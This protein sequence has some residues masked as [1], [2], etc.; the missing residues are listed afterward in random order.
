MRLLAKGLPLLLQLLLWSAISNYAF[1]QDCQ[2][3]INAS[4]QLCTDGQVT[5]STNQAETYLW[6][7]GATTRSITVSAPGNYT[8]TTT[9]A[10]GCQGTSAAYSVSGKPD[11]KV[12]D[13]MTF[14]T[15]CSYSGNES[16][17]ELTLDNASTTK[18]TN[19]RYEIAWGDGSTTQFGKEFETATHT[20]R[21]AGSFKLA[22]TAY[23]AEGCSS[24]HE[25]R[26]FIG[27][28]PSLGL[29]SRGNTNDCSPATFVFD[30][31]NTEG[32]SPQTVYT[33]QFDDGSA[34]MTFTH[35]NLPKTIEHTFT[36][37]S[38]GRPGSAFTLTATAVN[39]CG[40]TPAT[41]GGIKISKGPQA[42]FGV[43]KEV[44]CVNVPIKLTDKTITGFNANAFNDNAAATYAVNWEI[45][46]AEGW[47]YTSGNAKANN[48]MVVFTQPGTYTIRM[49]A[50]P[51]GVNTKC[52]SSVQERVITINEP[53]KADFILQGS[54]NC[55]PAQFKA[56]NSSTGDAL[57]YVWQVSP[58]EGWSYA[59]GT[60]EASAEPEF[61]FTK[62]GT[63]VVALSAINNC[64]TS[65]KDTT[66]TIQDM[67][68]AKLPER[69]VYCGPQTIAFSKDNPLH[70]PTY[71][72][73]FGEISGY[74]WSVKG[75]G[76]ATFTDATTANSAYPSITFE[77]AG[78]YTVQVVATNAC[79][80]SKAA[81][82]E[83][84][85]NPL[86][87]LQ[88][89]SPQASI[90]IGQSTTISVTGADTYTW[91]S[92]DGLSTTTGNT[93]HVAPTQTTTYTVTGTNTAT[94]CSATTTF[95]VM[96]NPLPEVQVSA[97]TEAICAGQGV[98]TL[99]ASGADTYTWAPADGLSATSGASVQATP[100]KT[101]S[102]TVTGYNAQTGCYST[103]TVI[104]NVNPLPVV[105]AGPDLTL[106]NTP[107]PTQLQANPAGG[108]WSG[109]QVTEAGVFTPPTTLGSYTLTY[110][111]T[112][113]LGCTA[114][115]TLVVHVTQTPVADAGPDFAVCLNSD[116][117]TL[118]AAPTGGVWSGSKLVSPEG[119]FTPSAT[120]THKLV[121][122][123]GQGS[124]ETSDE[125][126]I[127]V[128][129]LP[130]APKVAPATICPGSNATLIVSA[131]QG[132][133]VWYNAASDG[134]KLAE[135]DTFTTPILTKTTTYYVETTVAGGCTSP[136]QA[137]TVTVRPVTPAPVVEALTLCGPGQSARL[138]AVGT[139]SEYNWYTSPTGG[140]LIFSGQVYETKELQQ[141]T[142]FYVEAVQD[143]CVSSRTSVNVTVNPLIG[144][145]TVAAVTEICAGQT[146]AQLI[147]SSPLGGD[148]SY[149]YT[150]Q[151][152]TSGP[153]SDFKT[154]PGATGKNYQPGSLN[155]TTWFRR[156][157]N[158]ATCSS[159][160]E[161]VEVSVTPVISN[162]SVS[163]EAIICENTVPNRLTGSAPVGG[164]GSY[165][166][167]WEVSTTNESN[168]F[169]AAPGDNTIQSYQPQALAQT[170]WFRRK[171]YS[172]TCQEQ[173]SQPVKVTV[174]KAITQNTVRGEQT[175]CEGAVPAAFTG[176][177]P[178][179][180]NGDYIF[181]WEI[182]T[183]G[184]NFDTA[185]GQ[186]N[187]LHYSPQALTQNTWF[188]RVVS[189]G[190]CGP[191]TSNAILVEVN[192]ALSQNT[193][194]AD[195]VICSGTAPATLQGTA[196]QGGSGS[197][198]YRW[199]V[200]TTGA[201]GVFSPAT[202]TNSLQSYSAG[203]LT[204]TVWYKRE[205]TSGSCTSTSNTVEVTV[206]PLPSAPSVSPITVCEN[207]TATLTVQDQ[208]GDFAW[209][210]QPQGGTS[211]AQG[212]SFTTSPLGQSTTFYVESINTNGCGSPVRAAVRVTVEQ[213]LRNNS[214]LVPSAAICAG[215]LPAQLTGTI[216]AGGN[217][218]YTYTWESSTSGPTAGF[219]PVTGATA[220]T[221][222]P[223]ALS[224]TTWYR[225]VVRAGVCAELVSEAVEVKVWPAIGNNSISGAQTL[226]EGDVPA[227]LKGAAPTGGNGNYTYLW[228]QSTDGSTFSTAT[229]N[230]T[231]QDYTAQAPLVRNTWYRRVVTSGPCAGDISAAVKITVLP[232]I[233]QNELTSGPQT[234]C[235]GETP[236]VLTAQTPSGGTGTF[237]YTWEISTDG[238][239]YTAAP[240]TNS[241]AN[242]TPQALTKDTWFRRQ[243]KSGQC[244][245]ISGAV[246]VTV[247]KAIAG[248]SISQSQTICTD[249]A[250]A[251]LEGS[252]PQGGVSNYTY[253][254][255]YSTT[256][257]GSGFR[258]VSQ[259]GSGQHYQP[260]TL[261]TTTWF[262]RVVTSGACS[263]ISNVAEVTVS[264]AIQKN[265]IMA[266]QLIYAGQVP[267][268]L[269][270]ST[271]IGGNEQY[272]YLW[273]MSTDGQSFTSAAAP[274]TG[275]S[276]SPKAITKDTWFRRIVYSGG[277]KSISN[278]VRISVT[279]AIGN[280]NI[281]ADQIICFGN[282]PAILTGSEPKGGEGDYAYLWQQSTKGPG[283]GWLTAEGNSTQAQ[284]APAALTQDT[285]FRRIVVSGTHTDT[286]NA[287]MVQVKPAMSN[288][289]INTSQTI[290]YGTAP[291][292]L[293]GTLPS[294]GS[295]SYTYLWEMS[296]SG[297]SSGWTTAPGDNHRQDYI[298]GSL[299]KTTWFRRVVTSESCQGL[300][301]EPVKITVTPLPDSPLAKGASICAGNSIT[302][303]AQGKGSR[304]EW[305][306]S[307][308]GGNPIGTGNSFTTPVLQYTTTYYVQEVAQ[309]CASQ[310]TP[311]VVQVT[312]PN[313]S[314]GPDITVV[315][316]RSVQLQASG[317]VTYSWSPALGMDDPTSPTPTLTPDKTTI[318][319]VTVTTAGGCVFEDEVVVR[320]LPF[321]D[322]PNTFT[323]NLDGINDTWDIANITEYEQCEVQV[324]NQWGSQ[325]F[326]SKGY[327]QPW[328]G[329]M[330]GKELP[331]A[332]YYYV[333]K[334]GQQEKPLT[335]SVTIVK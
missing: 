150:W 97:D 7:N 274:N 249:T 178:Q 112:D 80:D 129:A 59:N 105:D 300:V 245:A 303:Q 166:Y 110:T 328:D 43:S 58:A 113:A 233:R 279:P 86:P 183:D 40:Q 334:L 263:S 286:S 258:T 64:N 48:P 65:L 44:G 290:C 161:A 332:T 314:A 53:A 325:V 165:T 145:N 205:V 28:N 176:T 321:V 192:P 306:A 19:T 149:T 25:E 295:G 246:Q 177:Q 130:A 24:T 88:V 94:G 138:Q 127:T 236:A 232:A 136:R 213:N 156:V 302:L 227:M 126:L 157:V 35:A 104:V 26:V 209:Y 155:R 27:S 255:E 68:L 10:D 237:V 143:G 285:W 29:A 131:P 160:S 144:Q 257:A 99:T 148:G 260:G 117:I 14:F 225:R 162:N 83:I 253:T 60:G 262:R 54:G 281:Q 147:G 46:P 55:A 291:S 184:Q 261:G 96:V 310:R 222:Q 122:T 71:D 294:G 56:Q 100:T 333:I 78:T 218:N 69:Q 216:P 32:N 140:T 20:Y 42:D 85:I 139:A 206:V 197:Y 15:S 315:K 135:G 256:G 102:Y 158:S 124:C 98:A 36:E 326:Y 200:S 199:L 323:P 171:V 82:Q 244:S 41:V 108:I 84:T 271:P 268:P 242:Y 2:P 1:A 169:T 201:N 239:T 248:N 296:T 309:S 301:S 196:P 45:L 111:Y 318:Y 93:V 234:I 270:G 240:G 329:R 106:C 95:T 119:V 175:V 266:P 322:I 125:V 317:G 101:T 259:N 264:P 123:Y 75:P 151:S 137:V 174:F 230:A 275:K 202:G 288:N 214:L 33:F 72:A 190:P 91:A 208:T 163:G 189:G 74:T 37:S 287:V 87:Q 210:M 204:G 194:S 284:Y 238:S 114:T 267:A 141:T 188:R 243:V 312:E 313:V 247:N 282:K 51:T 30:I 164:S 252:V 228:Q 67:P 6:S 278:V 241:N 89:N 79:G 121:Y 39:P 73:Q 304:L 61:T 12:A 179:G 22:V 62:A 231:Q 292:A 181:V 180:G 167:L 186:H 182:S 265:T 273:E 215:Q 11:A 153:N 212:R 168:G 13:P 76:T 305:F 195:Q 146:P 217:G 207:T 311:V 120:G 198:T 250:P 298:S 128:N 299:T 331:I 132:H 23:N 319:K 211:L 159:T 92:A 308:S 31:L 152:S 283:S 16:R 52:A 226:C 50:T 134:T 9:Q 269:T 63:Y 66:I 173:V 109:L 77:E 251:K 81:T 34:P 133:L 38:M 118:S 254:W 185:P 4:G 17:F 57:Q 49:T 193:I 21:S 289:K 327:K 154:I 18:E 277:C 115:D 221:Y 103:A 280:N 307:A 8:V 90:C 316:G 293:T 335:G 223:A 220:A 142:I 276:Y 330:N 297:G 107:V 170:S 203:T 70:T 5:L 3:T 116:A 191:S 47:S 224:E 187:G 229:G 219:S 172:G 235:E 320:V 272:T 324:F